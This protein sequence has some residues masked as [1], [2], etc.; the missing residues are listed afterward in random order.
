M[1]GHSHY[2]TIKRQKESEDAKRGQ[3]FSK[4]VKEISVAVKT[5][6][7]GDID[8]NYKLRVAVDRAKAANMPK[9]NVERAIKRS[10]ESAGKM[11]EITYEGFGPSGVSVIVEAATDNKN[12]T[13]QEIKNLF[14][15]GGGNLGGPGSVSYNFDAFGLIA[16]KKEKDTEDQT[17]RL[18]E[19]GAEDIEETEDAIEIY[20][21]PSKLTKVREDIESK[22]FKVTSF[23]LLQRPKVVKKIE[24]PNDAKKVLKFLDELEEQP[25]VQKVY[26][27]LDV[28]ED[29]VKEVESS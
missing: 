14:E 23:E 20:V 2:A 29:V 9:D 19:A 5:G 26:A 18:I 16:V 7:G 21:K 22:G 1:S 4:L 11:E 12:R 17:L 6:G 3:L 24:N 13:A 8:T 28:P 27:N 25:D 15:R 10:T